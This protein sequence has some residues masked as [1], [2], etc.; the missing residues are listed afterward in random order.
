[1]I[2][3]LILVFICLIFADFR[4]GSESDENKIERKVK[5]LCVVPNLQGFRFKNLKEC[6]IAYGFIRDNLSCSKNCLGLYSCINVCAENAISEKL[7][8]D[9][10]RCNGCNICIDVCPQGIIKPLLKNEEQ[11]I[12]CAT[13]LEPET[14][15]H[16]CK[17]GCVK[18][19]ICIGVCSKRAIKLDNDR[20]P[21]IDQ[22][23]CDNCG[24][25]IKKCP[26]EIIRETK[27]F[28]VKYL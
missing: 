24:I 20:I 1:M 21:E 5:I 16:I 13:D 11:Y 7:E 22:E 27:N 26:T 15:S 8:I 10:D 17:E 18:C 19:Y 2:Y 12:S 3:L 14:V 23:I 9:Y 4:N 25:C 28:H 6:N